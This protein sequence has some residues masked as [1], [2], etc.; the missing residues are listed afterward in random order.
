MSDEKL[1][2]GTQLGQYIVGEPIAAGGMAEVYHAT[3]LMPGRYNADIV[4]KRMHKHL[5][6]D[7]NFVSM[8]VDE[9]RILSRLDHPNIVQLFDFEATS[10]GVY[11]ILELVEGPDLLSLL[12]GAARRREPMQQELA[13]YITCHVLE[14]LDYAHS[15]ELKGRSLGIVHQ[16]VSPGN[17][18]ISKHGRVKLADF[19]IAKAND[20]DKEGEGESTLRGKYGYMSPEQLEGKGLD[21]RSDIFSVGIVLAELLMAKRLFSASNPLDVLLM[22]RN[23]DLSRLEQNDSHIDPQILLILGKALQRNRDERYTTASEFRDDLTEWLSS[24]KKRTNA[25]VLKKYMDEL[26][27]GGFIAPPKHGDGSSPITFSGTSTQARSRAAR[28]AALLGRQA[29]ELG[30]SGQH[31]PIQLGA[32]GVTS[33]SSRPEVLR[34]MDE[35]DYEEVSVESPLDAIDAL[36]G[37]YGDLQTLMPM[38]LIG[39]I[40]ATGRTG[41]LTLE[42]GDVLKEAYFESGD[43]V[44][45]ASNDPQERFGNFLILRGLLTKEE[46][47]SA[48]IAMPHFGGRLGQTLVGLKILKPVEAINLLAEQVGEKLLRT[49]CWDYG[50]FVWQDDKRNPH[51]SVSLHLNSTK[52][53]AQGVRSLAASR[54]KEWIEP[55]LALTPSFMEAAPF[56]TYEFGPSLTALLTTMDGTRSI[57]ALLASVSKDSH[58]VVSAAVYALMVTS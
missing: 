26:E 56:E 45:V 4:L 12:K 29:F 27:K 23:V 20:R 7:P 48:L 47:D 16:D 36:E 21:G 43:P 18:L 19:G 34:A 3:C 32:A 51:E 25:S 40:S 33:I 58:R 1:A 49:C 22:V 44:F 13:V 46:L 24:S 28:G 54:L 42:R 41:L 50:R 6:S 39:A 5:A 11:I 52:I 53:V 15:I 8:F 9:A 2:S 31:D 14:A 37:G 30:P 35:A 10:D 55:R 17:V 38:G 57:R